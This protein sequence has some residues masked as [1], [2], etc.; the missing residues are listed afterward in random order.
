MPGLPLFRPILL[1]GLVPVIAGCQMFA[2]EPL[3]V[4]SAGDRIQ[5]HLVQ[6]EGSL[7]FQP[8]GKPDALTLLPSDAPSVGH[9]IEVLP[10]GT[11]SFADLGGQLVIDRHA[12]TFQ[13]QRI[14]RLAPSGLEG[15]DALTPDTLFQ[16]EGTDPRWR[17]TVS[18]DG[19]L[20]QQP[21][22]PAVA[23][24]VLV[25]QLPGGSASITTEANG[26]RIELWLA[27]GDCV[28]AR[29]DRRYHMT[30]TLRL[31][32]RTQQ[33]CAFAGIANAN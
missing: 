29:G 28:E 24:P 27:P 19:L 10:P 23:L 15:C 26:Q 16:A 9:A 3:P 21:D 25:E 1:M 4:E 18:A 8:C 33:G 30:A 17:A 12:G 14:F 31:D 11:R 5:G 7:H 6:A 13:P 32:G 22:Q 20:L 2:T